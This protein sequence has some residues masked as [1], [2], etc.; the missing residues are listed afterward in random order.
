MYV[1]IN[2]LNQIF[3]FLG[4]V[5]FGGYFVICFT[6]CVK[7]VTNCAQIVD[8][9]VNTTQKLNNLYHKITKIFK[10]ICAQFVNKL[11]LCTNLCTVCAQLLQHDTHPINIYLAT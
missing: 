11:Y 8:T 5:Q 9:I 4:P 10:T 1:Y 6:N 3:I 7:M 2:F